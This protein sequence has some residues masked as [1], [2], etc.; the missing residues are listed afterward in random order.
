MTPTILK[1][2]KRFCLIY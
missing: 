1:L 2:I